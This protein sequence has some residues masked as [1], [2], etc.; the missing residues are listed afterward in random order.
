MDLLKEGLGPFVIREIRGAQGQEWWPRYQQANPSLRASS[1]T[2][3]DAQALL[4]L[5]RDEWRTTFTRTL[6]SFER[7]LIHELIEARNDW[8]HQRAFTTDDAERALDSIRRLLEAMS[9]EDQ[10]RAV[11]RERQVLRRQQYDEYARREERRATAAAIETDTTGGLRPWREVITP[12]P[13]VQRGAFQQAEFAA[14][15]AQVHRGEGMA[16]YADPVEFYRRTYLT[17]GLSTLLRNAM[18]RLG[19]KGGDPV[20]ELQTNFGGGKTHSMLALYHLASDQVDPQ[21]LPGMEPIL[22]QTETAGVDSVPYPYRAVLV[23][24][25]LGPNQVRHKDDGTETRTLWGELAW[26][27]GRRKGY[28]MVAESDRTGVSPGADVLAQLF[29]AYSPALILIDEWVAFV[30]QLYGVDGLAAGSFDANLSFAQALTEAVRQVPQTLLVASLPASDIE[31]GGAGGR[32]ALERLRNT[33]GRMQASWQPATTEEG[34][35]IVRRRLFEPIADAAGNTSRDAVI[36]AFIELYR[37]QAGQFPSV[38]NEA[39]YRRKME[40]AYPI[41]PELFRQLYEGWST[42]DKFQRTRGV[43]RLMASVIHTLWQRN[44]A[45]LLILPASIPMDAAPVVD[46]LMRYLDSPWKPVIETDVDGDASL[47]L[48]LDKANPN[49]GRLSATRRVA[50]T[51]YLGSAPT[52]NSANR[53]I[54]DTSIRL[55]SAQPGESVAVFGDAL[56]TLSGQATHLYVDGQKYWFSTQPSVTRTAQ[57]LAQSFSN[58]EI[59]HEVANRL[60][61]QASQRGDFAS[62]H[63]CPSSPADV[64]DEQSARLVILDP[65]HPHARGLGEGSPAVIFADGILRQRGE[66]QRQYRNALVFVAADRTTWPNLED[67]TRQYLAWKRIYEQR[68]QYNLDAFSENQARTK[69]DE[70]DRAVIARIPETFQWLLVPMQPNPKSPDIEWEEFRVQGDGSIAVRASQRLRSEG[71]LY[72]QWSGTLLRAELDRVPLWRGDHVGIR[73]LVDDFA[74]YLY[75]PRLKNADVL[76]EAIAGGLNNS[77]WST[78]TFAAAD[79]FDGERYVGLVAGTSQRPVV[80]PDTV[81]V[82]PEVALGQIKRE[83]VVD[84]RPIIDPLPPG[85]GDGEDDGGTGVGTG[86]TPPIIDPPPPVTPKT[87][88]YWATVEIDPT[89]MASQPAKIGQEIVQHLAALVG[90]DVRVTVEI[91]A[92]VPDGIPEDVRRVLSENSQT[93]RFSDHGFEES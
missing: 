15:L 69:R 5:M 75:L 30:R 43:L 92:R 19:G 13:D 88:R 27:L 64:R 82:R 22:R 3:L 81:L 38:T 78:E 72:T 61:D 2:D 8:A 58:D 68:E 84:P 90:A 14:D 71:T 47:P 25:A 6:G 33:F 41:H 80:T 44:D 74:Q 36:R 32:E 26:Q 56:R 7:N 93:L 16:E 57:E 63:P 89:A 20:I 39:D 54:D 23:G 11:E 18:L 24:T 35:E 45:S 62:V 48:Q 34:F 67:A 12:H 87:R 1:P 17:E 46:E 28:A 52:L 51:V 10:A 29:A 77:V 73:Q 31:I 85:P 91:D 55:G 70:Q 9:A 42:L 83:R 76:L 37:S 79:R 86:P 50:R 4:K 60:R 53:G 66:S 65:E 40:A 59:Y 21:D 49:F